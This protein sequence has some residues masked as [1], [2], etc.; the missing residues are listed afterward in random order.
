MIT[1]E[2][3]E[4]LATYQDK[5]LVFEYANGLQIAAGYHVTEV[6]NVTY[7]SMDC[8]GQANF[9]RETVVQLMG[10]GPKDTPEFMTAQK[11]L[12]IY[13]QVAASVPVRGESEIR[14]EYGS[15]ALPAIQYRVGQ[16]ALEG[17]HLVV[18]L[19]PPSVSCKANN[20][21]SAGCCTPLLE[22]AAPATGC[23]Q[24]APGL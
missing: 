6:M 2:L 24:T 8:G 7:E 3:L 1:R 18:R 5:P 20:R 17:D 16:I 12:G 11:F 22:V 21:A 10:P 15:A 14:F 23:C 9:W 4:T 13:N 19:T